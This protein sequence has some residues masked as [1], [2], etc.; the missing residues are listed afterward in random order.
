MK[1]NK[2]HGIVPQTIIKPVEEQT[3]ILKDT[4]HIPKAEKENMIP[5]LEKEMR[6]AAENLDFEL[7]IRLR[8]ELNRLK[9]RL[10]ALLKKVRFILLTDSLLFFF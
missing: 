2:E 7:A 3:I 10:R 5:Q 4:K 8:D 9:E 1:Y 6:E